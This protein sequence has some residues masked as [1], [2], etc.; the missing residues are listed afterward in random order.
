MKR[1]PELDAAYEEIDRLKGG[2][3]ELQEAVTGD[4]FDPLGFVERVTE[5]AEQMLDQKVAA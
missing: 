2:F 4:K 5:V 1:D 3:R